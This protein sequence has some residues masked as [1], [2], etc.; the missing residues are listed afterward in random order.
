M[1]GLRIL[2]EAQWHGK[3]SSDIGQKL[4][5][6]DSSNDLFIFEERCARDEIA[7]ALRQIPEGMYQLFEVEEAAEEDCDFMADSGRCYRRVN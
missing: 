1:Q 2:D 5:I 4:A 6:K 3:W 7:S